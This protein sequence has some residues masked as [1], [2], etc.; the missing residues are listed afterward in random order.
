MGGSW[1]VIL[2]FLG[3]FVA[4]AVFGGLFT[5]R[6]AGRRLA[7]EQQQQQQQSPATVV[8]VAPATQKPATNR[9]NAANN[10]NR[11]AVQTITPVMM[12]RLATQ[13]KLTDEQ[14]EKIKPIV[15]RAD[16]DMRFL[17]QE[18][19]HSTNRVLDRMHSDIAALLTDEQRAE[20][21]VMKR[22][23][24]DQMAK[25]E[26]ERRDEIRQRKQVKGAVDAASVTPPTVTPAKANN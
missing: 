26:K 1:K 20:L 11:I 15:A 24:Q 2:A 5:V 23:V 25:A 13:L 4:G 16:E 12:Q 21:E 6:S 7:E 18:N 3:V 9:P 19:F 22:N 8:N 10:A 14:R 17:R